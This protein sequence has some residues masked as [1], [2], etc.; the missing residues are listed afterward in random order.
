V[1]EFEDTEIKFDL[2][3]AISYISD[4]GHAGKQ[5]VI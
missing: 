2:L 5:L 3:W 4:S 1:R